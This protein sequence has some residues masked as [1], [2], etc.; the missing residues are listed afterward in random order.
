M[1]NKLIMPIVK[2]VGG[3]RQLLDEIEKRLPTKFNIYHEPFFGGGALLFYLQPK[4]A[5]IN[6]INDELM[7]TYQVVKDN[8]TELLTSLERHKNTPEYFYSMRDKDRN[9]QAFSEMT[10]IEKASRLIYLNKTC[11]NGLFRVNAAG[12]FNTPFGGYKNPNIVNKPVILA[13]SE[14]LNTNAIEIFSSDFE[15]VLKKAKENDFVYLDPPYDPIS[16]TAAFTGYNEG[17]FDKDEQLRLFKTCLDLNS[18]GVFFMQSNS[19][20]DFIINLYKDFKIDIVKAR[21]NVNSNAAGRSEIDE[22][23]IRN[24]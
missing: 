24:Y 10:I 5:V 21:R 11:Y 8:P 23:I 22:V 18:K 19:A 6:D 12:Q 9:E 3:K 20:T 17:G 2:W 13:V 4:K 7:T 1:K 15:K 16:N 14:Y